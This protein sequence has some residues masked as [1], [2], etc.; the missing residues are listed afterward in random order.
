MV[1]PA[2][3]FRLPCWLEHNKHKTC[4]YWIRCSKSAIKQH[5]HKC[6]KTKA[7]VAQQ[8]T[9]RINTSQACQNEIE[10]ER[11]KT[12]IHTHTPGG[13]VSPNKWLY[14]L[15]IWRNKTMLLWRDIM[16]CHDNKSVSGPAKGIKSRLLKQNHQP[17][18]VHGI[19]V[20][21]CA[22][23]LNCQCVSTAF[24]TTLIQALCSNCSGKPQ[25]RK[26][27]VNLLNATRQLPVDVLSRTLKYCP[28]TTPTSMALGTTGE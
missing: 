16:Q 11:E 17:P 25:A 27:R 3:F 15:C 2:S 19:C 8:P 22:I 21:R 20:L 26:W 4:R 10:S 14:H 28:M 5:L 6:R 24:C 18:S 12:H 1:Q 9:K 7:Y 13:S 23:C